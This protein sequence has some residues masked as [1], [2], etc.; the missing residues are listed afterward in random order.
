MELNTSPITPIGANWMIQRTH[1][2][3]ASDKSDKRSLVES[4]ADLRAT[5]I[6]IAHARTPRKFVLT[7]ALIGLSMAFRRTVLRTDMILSGAATFSADF[8]RIRVCGNKKLATTAQ[9]PA[10]S[11]PTIYRTI[12]VDILVFVPDLCWAIAAI[13]RINT[14]RGA[15]ALSAPTNRS[16]NNVK[17]A[18]CF[19]AITASEM[20]ITRPMM[21]CTIKLSLFQALKMD[22]I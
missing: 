5:P 12:T 9:S 17:N 1:L 11:V 10:E 16:P 4:D 15:I 2:V 22:F 20:P 21:I 14:I 19:G 13:T 7:I 8:A 6:I 18:S 3:I